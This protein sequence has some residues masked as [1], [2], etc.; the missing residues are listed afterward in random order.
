MHYNSHNAGTFGL[1]I[2]VNR[3]ALG[4]HS[5]TQD[6]TISKILYLFERFW[7]E[8]LRSSL[9]TERLGCPP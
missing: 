2:H 6:G 1:H 9:R 7:Q 5:A 4:E 8:I 3:D